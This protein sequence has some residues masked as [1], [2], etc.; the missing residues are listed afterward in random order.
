MKPFRQSLLLVLLTGTLSFAQNAVPSYLQVR[1]VS[2]GTVQSVSYKSQA[3]GT[4]RNMVVYRPAMGASNNPATGG[5][6][7]E[8]VVSDTSKINNQ[9]KFLWVSCGTEDTL[10]DSI[11]DFSLQLAKHKIEHTIA[12]RGGAHA[13]PVWQRNLNDV[14]PLLFPD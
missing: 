5:V 10:F 8:T 14:A 12:L 9:I 13:Y 3:L 2:H 1:N 6:D 11:R 7:F 4:D